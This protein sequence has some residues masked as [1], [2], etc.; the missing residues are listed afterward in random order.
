MAALSSI[1]IAAGIAASVGS[2]AVAIN[3]SNK[4]EDRA[5]KE[6][7]RREKEQNKLLAEAKDRDR[8]NEEVRVRDSARAKQRQNQ[9]TGQARNRGG[10]VVTNPLGIPGGVSGGGIKT[11][12]GS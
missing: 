2:T 5:D 3:S 11:V 6:T 9:A 4:A 12:L 10:T 8:L 7:K 1:L